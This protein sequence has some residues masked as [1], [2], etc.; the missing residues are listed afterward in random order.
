MIGGLSAVE[1]DIIPF[2]SVVGERAELAGLNIVGMKRRGLTRDA[3]HALRNSYKQLFEASEGTLHE[4]VEAFT[5]SGEHGVEVQEVLAFLSDE[6]SR[7][8]S[9]PKQ[10]AS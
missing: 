4:R 8:F 7:S 10:K 5:A 9:T 2:G 1:K 3:I 6:S